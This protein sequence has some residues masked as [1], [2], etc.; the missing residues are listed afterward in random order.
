MEEGNGKAREGSGA[1]AAAKRSLLGV[2]KECHCR[3]DLERFLV[4]AAAAG[5]RRGREGG[6]GCSGELLQQ[7]A[8][9]P[10][11]GDHSLTSIFKNLKI[12]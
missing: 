3:S 8:A 4:A 2:P 12:F 6:G 11:G 7:Q 9:V 5:E 1:T 10:G